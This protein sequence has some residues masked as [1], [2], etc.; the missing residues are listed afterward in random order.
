MRSIQPYVAM[1]VVSA[2][3]AGC[4]AKLNVSKTFMLPGDDTNNQIWE[5]PAQTSEQSVKITVT[6]KKGSPVEVF[7]VKASDVGETVHGDEKEKK[8]WEE[9]GFG[10]KR[11]TKSDTVTVKIPANVKYKVIV[12]QVEDAKEKSEVEVKI[13]N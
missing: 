12:M 2:A 6:V 8:A 4:Q 7:V 13:T 3:C 1:I 10:F 9:K 5:M 11:N